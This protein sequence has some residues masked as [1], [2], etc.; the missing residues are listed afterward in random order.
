[1]SLAFIERW[2]SRLPPEE[3][4]IPVLDCCGRLW[5]PRQVLEQVRS[6]KPPAELLQRLI[7]SGQAGPGLTGQVLSMPLALSLGTPQGRAV[8]GLLSARLEAV[9]KRY[10]GY[11]IGTLSGYELSASQ[12]LEDL[13]GGKLT[14]ALMQLLDAER[15]VLLKDLGVG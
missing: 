3:R 13:K 14:P 1:M 6:G 10:S 15:Q 12:L 7:E 4:D 5:T 11:R 2:Y 9:L 8:L